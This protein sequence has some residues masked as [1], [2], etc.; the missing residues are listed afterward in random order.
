MNRGNGL[1][2]MSD[3]EKYRAKIRDVVRGEYRGHTILGAPPPSSGGI[4]V[5][6]A[7]NILENFELADRDRYNPIT[8]H[9]IAEASRRAFADRARYLGDPEFVEIPSRLTDKAYARQL[10]ATIDLTRASSSAAITPE[11]AVA[12]ESPDTTHFS[13]VDGDGM[14]VSNTYTLEASWGSR[15]VVKDAGFVLNNEMGDFN[16]FPGKT[17]SQG[18]IGTDANTVAGG[19]RMLSSQSPV[20]VEKDGRLVLVTGS[21]GG[22]SIINTV[23]GILI[24][25]I[26]FKQTPVD[27]IAGA[28]MHH[29][30]FPDRIELERIQQPPH[31]GIVKALSAMGHELKGRPVQGS[32]HSIGVDPESGLLTG[33][34]DFRRGGQVAA[35]RDLSLASWDFSEPRSTSLLEVSSSDWASVDWS[36][37]IPGV[38]TDGCDHLRIHTSVGDTALASRVPLPP[39]SSTWSAEI[40]IDSARFSGEVKNETLRFSFGQTAVKS[41]DLDSDRTVAAMM[42][43]RLDA[44]GIVLQGQSGGATIGP[45][46][47]T[48]SNE[49]TEP[50]ILRLTVDTVQRQFMIASRPASVDRMT[51]HGTT[52]ISS[53][54]DINHFQLGIHHD[55]SQTGEYVD[56]DRVEVM[57]SVLDDHFPRQ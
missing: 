19:K 1:I 18:R 42:F 23:L 52:T 38:E 47:I 51:T 11:I 28:R 45:I 33:V 53:N 6:Q 36:A 35:V 56:V 50:L 3:L 15:I 26:D 22:R 21:P 16:W 44:D 9:L 7:L 29:Q 25:V 54:G 5:I 4:A 46:T 43:G 55:L 10:A 41:G 34:A 13:V 20:I 57:A 24:N 8:I 40:K 39:K 37:S 12:T 17:N 31:A 48:A 14:A 32:A 49:L 30:W 2:T 27:A